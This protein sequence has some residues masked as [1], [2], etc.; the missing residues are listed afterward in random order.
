MSQWE[1][2]RSLQVCIIY[3]SFCTQDG[4]TRKPRQGVAGIPGAGRVPHGC[5]AMCLLPSPETW[6]LNGRWVLSYEGYFWSRTW[7]Y[8]SR[9]A[10]FGH[11]NEVT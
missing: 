11:L 2:S 4:Q 5:L 1:I 7:T 8:N 3:V 6:S 9:H 10:S